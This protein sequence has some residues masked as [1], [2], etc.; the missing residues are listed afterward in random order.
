[1]FF[2][3]IVVKIND[4]F[5]SF[6]LLARTRWLGLIMDAGLLEGHLARREGKLTRHGQ[7]A[8]LE[9]FSKAAGMPFVS[10]DGKVTGGT[11]RPPC[12]Q[13]RGGR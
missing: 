13:R 2:A 3:K 7:E 11:R 5:L 10:N 6:I 1:M 4:L 8:R 9:E 12:R